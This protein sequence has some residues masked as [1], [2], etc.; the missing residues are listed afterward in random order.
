MK[1]KTAA[2]HLA[3]QLHKTAVSVRGLRF[4]QLFEAFSHDKLP[5]IGQNL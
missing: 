1:N 4:L 2:V 3:E 5:E